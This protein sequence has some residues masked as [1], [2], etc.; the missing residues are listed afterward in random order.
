ML[1]IQDRQFEL[2][3][4]VEEA[5]E[6]LEGFLGE[7]DAAQNHEGDND[8]GDCEMA[9][10]CQRDEDLDHR[11]PAIIHK[12]FE[13]YRKVGRLRHSI[14]KAIK[15]VDECEPVTEK[16]TAALLKLEQRQKNLGL[17]LQELRHG[18]ACVKR[19]MAS[20]ANDR[21]MDDTDEEDDT[22]LG[23]P[24]IAQPDD[25]DFSHIDRMQ[26]WMEHGQQQLH[27]QTA[28]AK[29][30]LAGA[31]ESLDA[32]GDLDGI[33]KLEDK[34]TAQMEVDDHIQGVNVGLADSKIKSGT[35]DNK[36]RHHSPVPR[37]QSTPSQNTRSTR[38]RRKSPPWS[39]RP[40]R[41]H[42]PSHSRHHRYPHHPK[43]YKAGHHHTTTMKQ[44]G[45]CA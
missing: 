2:G 38:R 20:L 37:R 15:D 26:E 31:L 10:I 19:E 11:L 36:K 45:P 1:N 34:D 6:A 25:D 18:M 21:D 3:F 17:V 43:H 33:G 23:D 40:F 39:C 32:L 4:K 22:E 42:S 14:A 13:L 5:E 28:N 7:I 44:P 27:L 41:C 12:Q 9:R 35:V 8:D 29:R 30:D 16:F 24:P